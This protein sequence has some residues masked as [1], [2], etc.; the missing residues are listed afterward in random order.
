MLRR[1]NEHVL[2]EGK[3]W[4]GGGDLLIDAEVF[5]DRGDAL[6]CVIDLLAE[7]NDVLEF[8]KESDPGGHHPDR[9]HTIA[10]CATTGGPLE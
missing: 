6:K 10:R 1:S 7:A 2:N 8:N 5:F 9:T 4:Y 3:Y